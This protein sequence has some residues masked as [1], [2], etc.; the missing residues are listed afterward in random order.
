MRIEEGYNN[1]F[2]G[3]C[4]SRFQGRQDVRN[5]IHDSHPNQKVYIFKYAGIV[6]PSGDVPAISSDDIY[7]EALFGNG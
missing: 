5:H 4:K 6:D 2:C 7:A 3:G 1:F